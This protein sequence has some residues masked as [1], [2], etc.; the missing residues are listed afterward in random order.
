M[1]LVV[2]VA[3]SLLVCSALVVLLKQQRA[4]SW[5]TFRLTLVWWGYQPQE[6]GEG[7]NITPIPA[8]MPGRALPCVQVRKERPRKLAGLPT[9]LALRGARA[10]P[11]MHGSVGVCA[12]VCA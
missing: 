8:V 10:V 4:R 2:C 9:K 5:E 6:Q 1:L 3:C 7:S 12:S 11:E